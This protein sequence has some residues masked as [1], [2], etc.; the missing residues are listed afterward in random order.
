MKKHKKTQAEIGKEAKLVSALA[1]AYEAMLAMRSM[2]EKADVSIRGG[3]LEQVINQ[4]AIKMKA[5][6]MPKET[7]EKDKVR[8][9]F[10]L[11]SEHAEKLQEILDDARIKVLSPSFSALAKLVFESGLN[12]F[13]ADYQRAI[14]TKE[15][16]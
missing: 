7:T 3:K 5:N 15:A 9:S 13:M 12:H 2:L 16:P 8:V 14:T 10:D 6:P 11:S 1:S 4:T